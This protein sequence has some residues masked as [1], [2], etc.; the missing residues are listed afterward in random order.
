MNKPKYKVTTNNHGEVA[1]L[2]THASTEAQAL[3]NAASQLAA[4]LHI[5]VAAATQRMSKPNATQ[6]QV[7]K[8]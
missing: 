8:E 7:I 1:T 3:R 2:Y 5:T 4:R 6:V